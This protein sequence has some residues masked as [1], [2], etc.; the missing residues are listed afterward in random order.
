MKTF[1]TTGDF[2]LVDPQS[3]VVFDP[4]VPTNVEN[5]TAFIL[6]RV[7]MKHLEEVGKPSDHPA[8]V[9]AVG[10]DAERLANPPEIKLPDPPKPAKGKGK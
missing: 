6:E 10:K 9:A 1:K 5:V 7:K 4:G 3:R 8:E 2:M